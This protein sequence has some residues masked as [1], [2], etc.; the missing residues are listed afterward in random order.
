[1]YSDSAVS[2][3]NNQVVPDRLGTALLSGGSRP[4]SVWRRG[5]LVD[6]ADDGDGF[7]CP[8]HGEVL[9]RGRAAAVVRPATGS[10]KPNATPLECASTAVS[11]RHAVTVPPGS[12]SRVTGAMGA[13]MRDLREH[14]TT[15]RLLTDSLTDSTARVDSKRGSCEETIATA[16]EAGMGAHR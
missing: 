7:R 4:S 6:R 2:R 15:T 3:A 12:P 16:A 1:M 5:T 8:V 10:A 11:I 14:A 13:P 9:A